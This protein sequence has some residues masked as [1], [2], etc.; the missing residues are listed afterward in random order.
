MRVK[1]TLSF[2]VF[3]AIIVFALGYF[4]SMGLT[5]GPP[6]A[7]TRISMDVPTINGL[8]V[9]SSVQ[10]RGVPIGKVSAIT[11][12]IGGATV[13]FYIDPNYKIPVDTDVRLEN[14]SALGEAY[15]GLI[16]R[17]ENGPTLHDGQRLGPEAVTRPPFIS[18]L[19]TTVVRVL[20]QLDPA[21]L[22]RIVNETNAA[23]PDPTTVA[24]NLVRTATILRNTAVNM[25]GKGRDLLDNFQALLRNASFVGPVLAFNAPQ[26]TPIG[27]DFDTVLAAGVDLYHRGGA[28]NILNFVNF[29]NRIGHLLDHSAGDLKVLTQSMLPY[30][31]DLSGALMNLDTGQV[32]TNILAGVPE[33][34]AVTLHVTIPPANEPPT[35][36]APH[37]VGN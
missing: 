10:L 21:A 22:E 29:I 37:R 14:L 28:Q 16:P 26:I 5:Y 9:G 36:D 6:P 19:A 31:N 33:D 7:E 35:P 4:N 3:A 8:V 25:H 34:G 30:L 15:I 18:E 2:I 32:F 12:T 27:H 23:L 20:N 24:P 13:D 11:T 1:G 17:R